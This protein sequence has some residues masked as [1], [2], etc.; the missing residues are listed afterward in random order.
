MDEPAKTAAQNPVL[1]EATRGEMVECRFRGAFALADSEG[2]ILAAAGD[3]DRPVYPRSAVKPLQALALVESGAAQA[4][5]LGSKEIALACASHGAEPRHLEAVAAW[6]KRLGLS[7]VDLECGAHAPTDP[8]SEAN[9]I[10]E[11]LSLGPLMNNCSGKH[12]GFLTLA[13]HR[14]W[15]TAGYIRYD[16]PVQVNL[17]Q[18]LGEMADYPLDD[19]PW[20]LDGCSIPTIA[21]PL[22]RIALAMARMANPAALAPERAAASARI[23]QAMAEEP[24]MVAGKNRCASETMARTSGRVLLKSGAEGVYCAF[25][26][27]KG[28]GLALKVDDGRKE[29]S[30]V[31]VGAILQRHGLLDSVAFQDL[32]GFFGRDIVNAAG[33]IVG[34]FRVAEEELLGEPLS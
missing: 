16:H 6:L 12:S 15:E 34:R 32:H 30:E 28:L 11:G 3:I 7:E 10:R 9:R 13:C 23:A 26:P 25:H 14:G 29:P 24:Y 17:R 4:F 33:R 8:D 2:R 18:I 19:A 31:L 21:L 5:G 22:E 27:G 20:G 1:V